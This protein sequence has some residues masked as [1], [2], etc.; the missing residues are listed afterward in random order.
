MRKG[1]LF[2][3]QNSL[4]DSIFKRPSPYRTLSGRKVFSG[5]GIMPDIFVPA[6]TTGNTE[7]VQELSNRQL[8]TA[9]VFDK[10]QPTLNK[11]ANA[12]AF[13]KQ[14]SV[15]D[16]G[17]D[18]FIQYASKTIKEMDSHELLVSRQSIKTTIKAMAARYKWGDNAYFEVINS[19][20]DALKKAVAAVK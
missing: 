16:D 2:S 12:N 7:I 14:Y 4:N 11:Y 20:D 3:A 5:G 13:I 1:E 15:S 18:D 8:F 19:N 10:L 17:F 9:Y 6:D